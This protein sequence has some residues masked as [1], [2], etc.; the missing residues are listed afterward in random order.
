MAENHIVHLFGKQKRKVRYQNANIKVYAYPSG[1]IKVK[2]RIVLDLVKLFLKSR[3]VFF[4]F[5]SLQNNSLITNR[6]D[7]FICVLPVLLH[8]PDIL[9]VQWIKLLQN[10]ILIKEIIP[11]K[12][13]VSL[14][15]YQISV[16]PFIDRKLGVKYFQFFKNIDAIHTISNDLLEQAVHF[17]ADPKI[18]TKITPAL[19]VDL[20]QFRDSKPLEKDGSIKIVTITNFHWKKGLAYAIEAVALFKKRG[21]QVKYDIIGSGFDSSEA[22]Y[23]IHDLGLEGVVELIGRIPY[24]EMPQKL[25]EYDVYLQPSIQEGFCNSVVEAQAV[26]LPCIVTNAEGLSENIEHGKTGW[27]VPKRSATAIADVLTGIVEMESKE[28]FE[29]QKAARN[30]VERLFD[31]KQQIMAFEAFYQN[32][33]DLSKE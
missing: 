33:P 27:V 4:K 31:I 1:S 29:M 14:R 20:F 10:L 5:W 28:L 22:L 18:T 16:S 7:Y 11:T 12:M 17:G 25:G 30:R 13:A 32:I 21:Q 2:V 6:L 19:N 23:H 8:P 15:G 3:K 26:G 24:Q 9:H